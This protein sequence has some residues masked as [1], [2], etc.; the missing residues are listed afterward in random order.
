MP[1]YEYV[2]HFVKTEKKI[3]VLLL[4]NVST[5][6]HNRMKRY[7]IRNTGVFFVL[8]AIMIY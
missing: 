5:D 4:Q 1:K 8:D 2:T 6:P 3:K 7:I